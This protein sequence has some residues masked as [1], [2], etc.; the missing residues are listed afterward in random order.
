MDKLKML[1]MHSMMISYGILVGIS[2][3]A[4]VYH[5]DVDFRWYHPISIL[6]TGLICAIPSLLLVCEKEL[7]RKQYIAKIILHCLIL[8]VVVMGLGKL[9]RWYASLVGAIFVA[10]EYFFVYIFVWVASTWMSLRDQ[11]HINAALK[12]IQDEE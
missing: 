1:F 7:P 4:V 3:E 11:Q 9:F 10:G 12:D 2:V 6:I 5:A 8:F